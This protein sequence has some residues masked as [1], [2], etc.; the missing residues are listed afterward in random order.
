[1]SQDTAY[2]KSFIL[3]FMALAVMAVVSFKIGISGEPLKHHAS[4]KSV[5]PATAENSD[6]LAPVGKI[7]IKSAAGT[8]TEAAAT[9]APATPESI[10]NSACSACHGSGVLGAPKFGTAADWTPRVA[11]GMDILV[12]HAIDGFNAMPPKGGQAALS[13]DEIKAV[14]QYMVDSTK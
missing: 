10:Y 8:T 2:V 6:V 1:V 9:T 4:A 12:K 11:Q 7:A 3:S 13:D 14:V 5:S